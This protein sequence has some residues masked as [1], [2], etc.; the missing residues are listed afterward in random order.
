M[1]RP[2]AVVALSALVAGACTGG[3]PAPRGTP[4]ARGT[5]GAPSATTPSGPEPVVL[6]VVVADD[7]GPLYLDLFDATT[8][9]DGMRVAVADVNGAGGVLGRPLA[10]RLH[11]RDPGDV[12]F[13]AE[14][15]EQLA[16]DPGTVAVLYVGPGGAVIEA[17]PA[18]ERAGTPVVLLHGDLYSS[19]ALFRQVFQ[20]TAPWLWQAHVIARYV[21]RDRRAR[22]VVFVGS[23]PG[24]D[25]AADV[26]RSALGYWGGTLGAAFTDRDADPS[27][28]LGRAGERAAGADWVVVFAP[29]GD[30]VVVVN[31]LEEEA[32]AQ[33]GNPGITASSALL[34]PDLRLAH[35][36]PG[37]TAAYVYSWAGW[38]EVIPRVFA[39]V[40]RFE[41]AMGQPPRGLEQEG[42]DAVLVLA[43]ALR[44]TDGHGGPALVRA[45]ERVRG[46]ALSSLPVSLGPDDHLFLPREQ[47]GLFAVPGPDELLDP[48]LAG[49][50]AWMPVMRTFTTDGRR[51]SVLERD[52]AV[53]FPFWR[54][55]RP[56]PN[57]WRSVYG[58]V[59]RPTDP[60]H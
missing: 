42:Y 51:T 28:G 30:A 19:R 27:T 18:V 8:Y 49:P 6:D 1:R 15:I 39:F 43:E 9:L 37:T 48:W 56:S 36:E 4:P 21:V 31:A 12:G 53:F 14:V 57:Y 34:V 2:L 38:A 50:G 11:D 10:L 60:L 45:L 20:T 58:I 54:E 40:R 32:A 22:D 17:R 47:I 23:G 5:G 33:G 25:V 59:T 41:R 46:M 16:T 3:G 52:R 26:F 13:A 35:P 44:R 24:A 29:P 7:F 55:D